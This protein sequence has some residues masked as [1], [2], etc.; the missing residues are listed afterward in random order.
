MKYALKK[1]MRR[2]KTYLNSPLRLFLSCLPLICQS[3]PIYLLSIWPSDVDQW[4]RLSTANNEQ[5]SRGQF[6]FNLLCFPMWA[7][8]ASV[9]RKSKLLDCSGFR[10]QLT[11][12][13]PVLYDSEFFRERY[14]IRLLGTESKTWPFRVLGIKEVREQVLPAKMKG[15]ENPL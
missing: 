1:A 2:K 7:Q 14:Y 6:L 11:L 13:S 12:H 8:T 3:P 9:T 15:S 5:D 4:G 10:R